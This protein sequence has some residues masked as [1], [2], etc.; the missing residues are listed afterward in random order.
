MDQSQGLQQISFSSLWHVMGPELVLV[1]F[2]FLILVF[3]LFV[4][5][6]SSRRVSPWIGVV[7]LLIGLGLVIR[8]FFVVASSGIGQL[9]NALYV[10]D[11]YGNVFKLIFIVG[12][13]LTLI[14]SI[15]FFKKNEQVKVAEYSYLL[16][17]ATVGA[18]VMASA[19]DLITLFVGLELLSISSY[20]LVAIRR[21]HAKGAEGA[22]KYLVVG[23][24]ASAIALYGMSFI[25]GATGMTNIAQAAQ[26]IAQEWVSMKPLLMLGFLLMLIG[27]GVKVSL[28]PFHQW[29]PDT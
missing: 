20:V 9:S 23:S 2:G 1:V 17:F 3:D 19:F 10:L 7:G 25:Y 5:K 4:S 6:Q 22:M 13:L 11:D 16:L 21:N 24:I 12:T 29:A 8:N 18:M 27:F 15:D 14:M 26:T 28:V